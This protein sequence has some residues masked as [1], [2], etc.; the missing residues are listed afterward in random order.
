MAELYVNSDVK[1]NNT[2]HQD[3][4]LNEMTNEINSTNKEAISHNELDRL[5]INGNKD[6]TGGVHI[7]GVNII[8]I[9][10]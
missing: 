10:F 2:V 1:I 9:Y 6:Y 5:V 4:N 3:L 8:I 7:K